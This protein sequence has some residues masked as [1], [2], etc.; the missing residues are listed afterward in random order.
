MY[1]RLAD[2][3][4]LPEVLNF[5]RRFWASLDYSRHIPFDVKTSLQTL[6]DMLADGML[7]VAEEDLILAGMIGGVVSHSF[8][9]ANTLVGAELF[10]WVQPEFRRSGAGK[11]L[12]DAI[13]A[14]ARERGCTLWSMIAIDTMGAEKVGA[15]YERAGYTRTEWSYAKVL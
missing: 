10:F 5:C 11:A 1:A 14:R 15:M 13:E 3:A 6:Q 12:M 9:N 4:D 7:F 8:V 2:K